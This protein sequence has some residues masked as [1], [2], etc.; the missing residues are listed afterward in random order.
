MYYNSKYSDIVG[1]T[2]EANY[3]PLQQHSYMV[4]AVKVVRNKINA[5]AINIFLVIYVVFCSV[6][7]HT[8]TICVHIVSVLSVLGWVASSY[9]LY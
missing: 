7:S 8:S 6:I 1:R 3:A 9:C 2:A 5:M 4:A